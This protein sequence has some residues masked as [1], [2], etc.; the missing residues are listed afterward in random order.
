[1]FLVCGYNLES[2][3]QAVITWTNPQGRSITNSDRYSMNNGPEVVQLSIANVSKNDHGTWSCTMEVSSSEAH[4]CHPDQERPS[5][6]K[7][8]EVLLIVVSK[9]L[10]DSFI[11]ELMAMLW[12][13]PPSEPHDLRVVEINSSSVRVCWNEPLKH[14]SPY[15]TGYKLC[16]SGICEDV[17]VRDCVEVNHLKQ[18][19]T[20][21]FT[22]YAISESG[23]VS[24]ESLP[25]NTVMF[26]M[27]KS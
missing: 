24:A 18:E 4:D 9:F 5:R 1:M 27:G 25:S 3:P 10:V 19:K 21:K 7:D 11:I 17:D 22:I 6:R 20:Y 2:N 23:N 26:I 15:L 13:G 16:Y 12:S 14:G 8:Y